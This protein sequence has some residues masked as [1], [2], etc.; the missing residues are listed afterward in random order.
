MSLS[1]DN[2]LLKKAGVSESELK[3]ELAIALYKRGKFSIGQ[4]SSFAEISQI[5]F[6][7]ELGIRNESINYD[8]DD[9]EEDLKNLESFS[10]N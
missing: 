8:V 2:E 1:F 6:Q 4:A 10:K 9:L 5:Q 7:H 3:I